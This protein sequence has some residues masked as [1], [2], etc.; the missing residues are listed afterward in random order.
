MLIL[1]SEIASAEIKNA[2]P[3]EQEDDFFFCRGWKKM[4]FNQFSW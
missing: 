1:K 3:K 2:E 4:Y